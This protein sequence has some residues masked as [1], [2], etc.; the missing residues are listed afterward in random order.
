MEEKAQHCP[1]QPSRKAL[2]KQLPFGQNYI[3]SRPMALRPLSE[4]PVLYSLAFAPA[5]L[6][7]YRGLCAVLPG[8]MPTS[9]V[10]GL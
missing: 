10:Y 5:H 8:S 6:Q 1:A 4:Y 9:S 3:V 2:F 7:T